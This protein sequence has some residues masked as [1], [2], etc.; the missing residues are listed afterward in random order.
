MD[1]SD[2]ARILV[3]DDDILILELVRD[4]LSA[5][6]AVTT[7]LDA[8]RGLDRLYCEQFD[9]LILDL[10]MP[11]LDG[12]EVIRRV[13]AR[14]SCARIPILVISA[15]DELRNRI[16]LAE[17]QGVLGKPFAIDKLQKMIA[18]ILMSARPAGG[19]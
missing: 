17:V 14:P 12:K 1:I 6:Y 18:K 15:Y 7:E 4:V 2:P 10:G 13:R 9:L 11:L 16:D 19:D 5:S 3:L 8:R